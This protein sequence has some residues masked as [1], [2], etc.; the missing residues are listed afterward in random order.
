MAQISV[1]TDIMR[2]LGQ[3]FVAVSHDL[4][5]VQRPRIE[6]LISQLEY[7]WQGQS[8]A[9]FENLFAEWRHEVHEVVEIGYQ[10]GQHLEQT[11]QAFDNADQS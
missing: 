2:Q 5:D 4:W 8:R 7:S 3:C 1:N 9:K 10:I 6:N 11:A